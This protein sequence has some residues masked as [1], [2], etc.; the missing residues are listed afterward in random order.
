[1]EAALEVT[2]RYC[3]PEMERYVQCVV[4]NPLSWHR[5]CYHLKMSV[6]QCAS[7]HPIIRQIRQDCAEPFQDF[8]LCL[9][10]NEANV[11]NCT[12]HMRRFLQCV[13]QVQ[14]PTKPN[15]LQ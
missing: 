10:K 14:L 11:R 5:D 9:R 15:S 2:A 13:E 7:S 12:E 8:D 4:A 6:A 1:M 3:G